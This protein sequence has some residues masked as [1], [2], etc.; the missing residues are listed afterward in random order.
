MKNCYFYHSNEKHERT[1][2]KVVEQWRDERVDPWTSL[3]L[4][5][6]G[7]NFV[8]NEHLKLV[9]TGRKAFPPPGVAAV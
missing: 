7:R 3:H 1:K 6:P 4:L 2:T 9:A 5:A 8:A